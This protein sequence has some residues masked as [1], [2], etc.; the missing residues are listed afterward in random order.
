[1]LV[2]G[3]LRHRYMYIQHDNFRSYSMWLKLQNFVVLNLPTNL[4][5]VR[6]RP[7]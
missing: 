4:W 3:P 5:L 7:R 6:D 1:M 2:V